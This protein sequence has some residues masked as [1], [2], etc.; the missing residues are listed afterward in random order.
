M[1]YRLEANAP[2]RRN[3]TEVTN[4]AEVIMSKTRD[5][6]EVIDVILKHVPANLIELHAK[7]TEI[8]EDS[9]FRP[10]EGKQASWILLRDTLRAFL[11]M[12]PRRNWEIKI[13]DIIEG[14]DQTDSC[15]PT[16]A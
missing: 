14:R 2:I 1:G 15:N 6:V 16:E 5:P 12:P 9:F 11:S 10:P 3:G 7:L 13:S 4:N 8:Q